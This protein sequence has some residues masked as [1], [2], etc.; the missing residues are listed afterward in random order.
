LLRRSRLATAAIPVIA[1]V[2]LKRPLG[3]IATFRHGRG[4]MVVVGAV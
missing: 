1:I 2:A 4:R 3:A